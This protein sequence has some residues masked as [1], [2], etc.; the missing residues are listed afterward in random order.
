MINNYVLKFIVLEENS[1]I[2]RTGCDKQTSIFKD[3]LILRS[4]NTQKDI[5]QIR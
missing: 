2:V 3:T 4:Y 1:A 5:V